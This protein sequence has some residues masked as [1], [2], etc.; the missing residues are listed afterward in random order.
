VILGIGI[1]LV[2]VERIR[3]LRERRGPRG[4]ERLFTPRELA[5][6]LLHTGPDPSLAARV[7][8]KEAYYKAVGT[9]VGAH[10]GWRDVEVARRDNGRP[11]LILHG[12]AAR[13]ARER[14]V[15]RV[16][17]ALTHTSDVAAATVTLEG[18]DPHDATDSWDGEGNV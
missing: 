15:R 1:D 5:H 16:H 11:L 2:S 3:L 10:G 6:C 9:G 14:G 7:A 8:A 4:L 12:A 18:V 13:H 17:L